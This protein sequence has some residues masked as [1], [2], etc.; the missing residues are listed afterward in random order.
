[1]NRQTLTE[2]IEYARKFFPQHAA[3]I[4]DALEMFGFTLDDLLNKLNGELMLAHKNREYDK[5]N[6]LVELSKTVTEIQ[7]EISRYVALMHIEEEDEE[8]ETAEEEE[9]DSGQKTVLD[10]AQYAVDST[11]PH[12]VDESFTNTKVAAFMLKNK[13]LEV[14]NWKDMLLKTC[15][16]L[17]DLD[18]DRF[19]RLVND[20]QMRGRKI[21]YFSKTLVV[22]KNAKLKDLDIYVWTNQSANSIKN[23]IKKM[24]IKYGIKVNDCQIFLRADYSP[25]H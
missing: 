7:D 19:M 11:V 10:Y 18:A 2:R 23:L 22:G 20:P 9:P 13:R 8:E 24:L 17:H 16:Y 3:E 5:S 6:E 21:Q 1:M 15:E 25:L 14:N 12:S 4:S